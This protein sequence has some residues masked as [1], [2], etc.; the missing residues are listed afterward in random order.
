MFR[1]ARLLSALERALAERKLPTD[2]AQAL[3]WVGEYPALIEGS[4]DNLK[5]TSERDLLIA[6]ALLSARR[7]GNAISGGR[8]A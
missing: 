2:E 1:H 8:G 7:A 6:E 3:E 4:A 5:I